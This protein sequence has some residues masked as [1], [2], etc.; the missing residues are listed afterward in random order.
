MTDVIVWS[1][2]KVNQM[3]RDQFGDQ[4]TFAQL[5]AWADENHYMPY[6]IRRDPQYRIS[7][8]VYRIPSEG[9]PLSSFGPKNED[10]DNYQPVVAVQDEAMSL[11]V[12][13]VHR[14]MEDLKSDASLLSKIPAVVPE[15]VP[16]GDFS[17]IRQVVKSRKFFPIFITG[18]SGIGKTMFVEQACALEQ[19]EYIRLNV[20]TESDEDD[21]LGGFRLKDGQTYFELGPV[22]VAMLR[23]SVL[24]IDEIDLASP[25]IMCLQPVME[26][27]PITLKKLG[28][29]VFPEPGFTVFATAN[30]KGR[31]DE[32]GRF[33]GTGLLNEAFLERFPVTI[34]QDFPN[35][36]VEYSILEKT[37][38]A[39]G[40]TMTATSRVFFQTLCKWAAAIR[41]TYKEQALEDIITTRRLVHIVRAF[42]IFGADYNAQALSLSLGT[43][44]FERKVADEFAD[45]YNKLAPDAANTPSSAGKR[46][47]KL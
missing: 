41:K 27:K 42:Y 25:K 37:F 10:R 24:L 17:T 1:Q 47:P 19:R 31:G 35:E 14:R 22:V 4:I 16:F 11:T 7:R 23:G 8:G 9:A 32:H 36:Q 46:P 6:W 39:Y 38:A 45:L 34:V 29:Q 26:G 21:F 20:T 28:I 33:I 44:R 15:F 2:A 18:E 43:N 5:M 30:T 40:G 12:T 13:D 3:L